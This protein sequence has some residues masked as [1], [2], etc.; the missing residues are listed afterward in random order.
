MKQFRQWGIVLITIL[1][2]TA[3]S[4]ED[5]QELS[6]K[7]DSL[8]E[9]AYK[10]KDYNQILQL[11][12]SL[13][14]TGIITPAK[15]YYWLGYASDRMKKLRMAEFYWKASM[16]A[17]AKS[18]SEENVDFYAKSAS[19]LTNLLSV[20]GDY[21]SAL[22][23]AIP[24]SQRLEQ[25]ECDSISDYVNLL[26]YIGCCQAGLGYSG[27][28]TFDGFERAYKIH[29]NNIEN[30]HTDEAY[31]NAIA[32]L[33]NIAYACNQTKNYMAALNWIGHFG[34]LLGEYEQRPSTDGDYVDKQVA[35]FA[36][37]KAIALEGLDR[38]TEAANVYENYLNTDYSQ[39]PE[40]RI[41]ANDY[42]V[43]ANRWEEAADNYRSLDAILGQRK[44]SYSMDDIKD[45]V[46]KKYQAN[47][48]AGRRDSAIAVS[49][50]ISNALEKAFK[51][52][53]ATD[54]E[55]QAT[56]VQKVE[57][58]TE[59]KA[60]DERMKTY[61][62]LGIFGLVILGFIAYLIIRRYSNQKMKEAY[63]SLSEDYDILEQETTEKERAATEHRITESIQQRMIPMELPKYR[64]LGLYASLIPGNGACG[65]LYD[66]LIR[67]G[68]LFFCIGNPIDKEAQSAVLAG[69]AW[70]LF[71]NISYHEDRPEVIVNFI[72][73]ALTMS[74][75]KQRGVSL[76]VGVLDLDTWLLTYCNAEH[77]AP[78][79]LTDE[80]NQ[81]PVDEN[82]PIGTRPNWD[83]TAQEITIE[84][85]T[86]LYLYTSGLALARNSKR[87]QYG[88]KMVHGA[89]LQAM[90]LDPSPKPFVENIQKA[91]D[92]FVES[93]P[94]SRDMTMLV[95][96][97]TS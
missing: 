8:I 61:G 55:E 95:I 25:L 31:K 58:M 24:A 94:Q 41:N 42:L 76:F 97:R 84:K 67:D 2:L 62:L 51:Q 16:D 87:R 78:L 50:Q 75:E 12:D 10:K 66:C 30:D 46:L 65:D 68:K 92:K 33:V 37:Y 21:E 86:M 13:E 5:K 79:L 73:N 69:M 64:G 74:G 72:N 17:A 38:K 91:I 82:V 35:R 70:A 43:A 93:T 20:R 49:L 80:V 44:G 52:A 11:A 53:K 47:L 56:I 32:G 88:E 45:L 36:I 85:G 28:S 54:A 14:R 40:G 63:Q 96:R 22:K 39:T 57:Q 77:T 9:T 18:T 83:F 1:L 81:L 6:K 59:Q 15:A 27:E 90:K 3:C 89:A 34:E 48:L 71:R 7:A 26:I 23:I 4:E 29:L 60:K 19:R